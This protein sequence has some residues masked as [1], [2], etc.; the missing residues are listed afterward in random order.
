MAWFIQ[1]KINNKDVYSLTTP[2]HVRGLH[3]IGLSKNGA[4]LLSL[5]VNSNPNTRHMDMILEKF[6][7][8]N[9]SSVNVVSYHLE[10]YIKGHRGAIFQDREQFKSEIPSR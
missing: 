2:I 10:S 5:F 4:K 1:Y 6:V 8:T 9:S 3:A 7:N